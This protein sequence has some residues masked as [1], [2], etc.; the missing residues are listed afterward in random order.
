MFPNESLLRWTAAIWAAVDFVGRIANA[1]KRKCDTVSVSP[2]LFAAALLL[3]RGVSELHRYP[4]RASGRGAFENQLLPSLPR[5][6]RISSFCESVIG[7][8]FA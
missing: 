5:L 3:Q 8:G 4:E 7:K 6:G 1:G 2:S